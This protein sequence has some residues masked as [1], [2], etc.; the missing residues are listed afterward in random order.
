LQ[1]ARRNRHAG[2]FD[3]HERK[4]DQE[5]FNMTHKPLLLATLLVAIAGPAFAQQSQMPAPQAGNGQ[6]P[7]P[8]E[9][10]DRNDDGVITRE[11]V[12]AARTASFTNLDTD[13]DGFISREEMERQQTGYRSQD[14][15]MVH[16][17][18]PYRGGGINLQRAD[19]NRDGTITR[20]EFDAAFE[21]SPMHNPAFVSLLRT[22][23][24]EAID[25]NRDGT[26]SSAEI[27]D[28]PNRPRRVTKGA[29]F[30]ADG[31]PPP[32][33]PANPNAA[34]R[35]NPDTNNDQKISLAE[36]LARPDPMFDRGDA[37]KD[38]RV[39][40]EEAA[41]A[42]RQGRTVTTTSTKRPW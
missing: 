14:G 37:N 41:A 30:L 22:S 1:R 4:F 19:A 36:W 9:R 34:R 23:A 6:R 26:I 3:G 32:H 31:P 12:T 29:S 24:F 40:R 11:E 13:R 28:A 33:E 20:A 21:D 35:P 18:A 42:M 5:I 39:T 8:F 38:G 27:A 16:R 2:P 15:R 17:S 7:S 10:L 25:T